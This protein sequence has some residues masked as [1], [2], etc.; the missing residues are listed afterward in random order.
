MSAG[1]LADARDA[2]SPGEAATTRND[3]GKWCA[4]SGMDTCEALASAL[5]N[6]GWHERKLQAALWWLCE[7]RRREAHGT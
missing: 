5:D 7:D 1:T 3:H 2:G 6:R 4:Y